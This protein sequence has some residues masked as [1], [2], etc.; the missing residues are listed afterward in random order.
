MGWCQS[1]GTAP[2]MAVNLGT[3]HPQQSMLRTIPL[4]RLLG[5]LLRK[6]T[7]DTQRDRTFGVQDS[8]S[9]Q[10][11][12]REREP[13]QVACLVGV[14]CCS[15]KSARGCASSGAPTRPAT[16][17]SYGP[18]SAVTDGVAHRHP[19]PNRTIPA[20][21]GTSRTLVPCDESKRSQVFGVDRAAAGERSAYRGEI[22]I[23]CGQVNEG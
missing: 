11:F 7:S 1:L 13:T 3:A 21:V 15:T 18:A 19:L 16:G 5:C 12:E 17:T 8:S 23:G 4:E 20:T 9:G 10:I 2:M 6:E 14:R 22:N